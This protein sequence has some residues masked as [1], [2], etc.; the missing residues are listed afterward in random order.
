MGNLGQMNGSRRPNISRMNYHDS[1]QA[2][3]YQDHRQS[4]QDHRQSSHEGRQHDS[5]PHDSRQHDH[6][7][8]DSRQHEN[9]QPVPH[10]MSQSSGGNTQHDELI[11]YIFDSWSKVEMDK[12]SNNVMYYQE[13]EN[14]HLKV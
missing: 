11:K 12:G 7:P 8:H 5:R 2:S 10:Q 3:S 13:H 9:R 4:Y 14:H 1:R 6:R